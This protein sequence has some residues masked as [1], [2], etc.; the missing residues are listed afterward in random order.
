VF[1]DPNSLWDAT[2]LR[3]N[4]AVTGLYFVSLQRRVNSAVPV[5]PYIRLNGTI[6][7]TQT[8]NNA[9]SYDGAS[10]GFAM[11]SAGDYIEA[12]WYQAANYTFIGGEP[13]V[14]KLVG[15]F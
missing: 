15:P 8:I 3:F 11:L 13:Y 7:V 14:F 4:I 5:A 6:T 2:N 9:N 10:M 1:A 12:I